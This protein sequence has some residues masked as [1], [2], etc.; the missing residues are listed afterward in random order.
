MPRRVA[1][2]PQR[3]DAGNQHGVAV[4]QAPAVA[5]QVEVLPVVEVGEERG[6]V[7]R[8]GVLVLLRDQLGGRK[9]VGAAGMVEVQVR[10]HDQVDVGGLEP[11]RVEAMHQEVVVAEAGEG[12]PAQEA[13]DGA[14]GDAG[15]EEDDAVAGADQV[16]RH[17][18]RHALGGALAVEEARRLEPHE[19]VLQRV[20][21]LDRHS[22]LTRPALA[23]AR[24]AARRGAPGR[25]P[26]RRPRSCGRPSG[27][28]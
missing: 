16:A 1:V 2:A 10:E 19:A 15:V 24:G 5:G 27:P 12:I 9:D 22:G 6:G 4:E 11:E 3:G 26:D 21:R 8:V 7:L 20:E 25:P 14:R 18:D 28:S 13:G 23:V 17:R